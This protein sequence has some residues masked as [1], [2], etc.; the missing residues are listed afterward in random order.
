M[1]RRVLF[2]SVKAGAVLPMGPEVQYAAE[3]PWDDLQIRVYAGADGSFTLY[4]DEG[5]G[6]GYEKGACSTIAFDWN[7]A[8]G[9]LTIGP[10]QGSYPG[11]IAGRTFRIVI[12]RPGAGT[13]L[14]NTSCD[15]EV[16]YDG[17]KV[18]VDMN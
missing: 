10:R 12:V 11:M 7:D 8:A 14:D 18:S 16:R 5:D 3:K 2:R 1:F 17:D 9:V 6:Y 15:R 4:E 13:G